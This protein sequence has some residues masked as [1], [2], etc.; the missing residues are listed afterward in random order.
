MFCSS[1]SGHLSFLLNHDSA[2]L[3]GSLTAVITNPLWLIRVRMFTSEP[4]DPGAYRGLW[5][6]SVYIPSGSDFLTSSSDG[7]S[8]IFR[9][10]GIPGLFRG[11]SLALVGVSNGAIQFM[12]YEKMKKWGFDQKKKR[13]QRS[14][15][16]WT[17]EV[18]KLVSF[19]FIVLFFL[20]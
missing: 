11:T 8:T 17:P 7:L 5:S 12:V 10:E 6:E 9:T 3:L 4:N 18:D 20:L 19:R 16:E 14:G 13:F 2:I 15:R 1:K